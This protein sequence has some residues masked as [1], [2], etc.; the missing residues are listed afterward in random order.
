MKK[1]KKIVLLFF[2]LWAIIPNGM[3]QSIA[4]LDKKTSFKSF[5][6]IEA[7]FGISTKEEMSWTEYQFYQFYI[8][9]DNAKLSYKTLVYGA[10]FIKGVELQHYF[11]AGLGLSYSYYK[12]KDKTVPYFSN[13]IIYPNSI[14]THKIPLFLY[15]RSDFFDKKVSP[16]IDFKIGNNFLYMKESV[17]IIETDGCFVASEYG[18]FRLKNGLFFASNI[19]VCLEI[20]SKT[21][22]NISA[23]YQYVS[24]SYDL[25]DY[26][27]LY[28]NKKGDKYI[29]TGYIVVDHQ[30]L[31]NVGVSF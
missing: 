5:Y 11:K 18:K 29:K 6:L 12:Q 26:V 8:N 20:D 10:S 19:G 21:A 30:F 24:R 13:N 31:L 22:L 9:D 16:Y 2:C 28:L 27:P 3:S 14:I 4:D 17:D 23:G 7:N 25:F 1:V 15:L